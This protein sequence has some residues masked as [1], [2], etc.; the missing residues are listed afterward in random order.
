MGKI[1]VR[2][3]PGI[4]CRDN[5]IDD[6][7]ASLQQRV[8]GS[9]ILLMSALT[10]L[11][12]LGWLPGAWHP[13]WIAGLAA[14]IA[15][16]LLFADTSR[17][18]KIQVSLIL[19][20]GIGL[21]AYARQR[22]APVDFGFVISTNTGLLTMIGAVGFLR[23]VVIPELQQQEALPIGKRAFLHT[24]IGLNLSSSVI[25]ISAPILIS[26]RIHL[27][28]PLQRFTAQTFTRVFCGV[29]SWSPFFGAMG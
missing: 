25:N 26:D 6:A 8:S 27:Q 17:V 11:S 24:L 13:L 5:S 12:G 15:A 28:R 22:A 2:S 10:I 21:I 19:L 14:W 7:P 18:L 4:S 9:L 1:R 23:L 16:L 3:G 20:I 29:S